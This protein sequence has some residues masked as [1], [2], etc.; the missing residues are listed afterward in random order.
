LRTRALPACGGDAVDHQAEQ[1][2]RAGDRVA[3][4]FAGGLD[5]INALDLI[6]GIAAFNFAVDRRVAE[7]ETT[8]ADPIGDYRSKII[9]CSSGLKVEPCTV[10]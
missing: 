10:H 2:V 9:L 4:P 7:K 5:R 1:A 8:G 6:A 3:V